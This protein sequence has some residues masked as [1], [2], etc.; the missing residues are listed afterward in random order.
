HASVPHKSRNPN[1]ALAD[2]LQKLAAA[3]PDL[4]AHPLL[5]QTTVSPTIIEV[6]TQSPNVTP[7]WTRVLLDFRTASE[8]LHSLQTLVHEWAGDW[9]HTITNAWCAPPEPFADSAETIYGFYTP[10]EDEAVQKAKAAIAQ[11]MGRE[12]KLMRYGFATDGR[13]FMSLNAPIIGY[14]P[15]EEDQAHIAGESISIAKM[16]ESLRGYLHLLRA[17]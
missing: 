11:G 9:P 10:P 7:A 2:F 14:S 12:P 13:H 16:G 5:G 8:S 15:A 17:F 3:K 1:F 6:D 4:S